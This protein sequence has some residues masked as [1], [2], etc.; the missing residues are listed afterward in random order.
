MANDVGRP[1]LLEDK[2][3]MLKIKELYLDG[4]TEDSIQEI[5]EVPKG[6]WNYWKHMNFHN[7][8]DILLS[9][10]HERMLNKAENNLDV[11]ME[12]E[13]DRVK[14][15]ASKFVAETIGKK[16]YSKRVE[17]SGIDGKE[18]PTP[19]LNAYV[20]NNDKP[21]ENISNEQE[22]S[23]SSGGDISIE[24]NIDTSLANQPSTDGQGEDTILGSLGINTTP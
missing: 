11:L 15:D 4:M 3:F 14:L 23:S 7:F 6:T 8:K 1:T 9:Y 13:D 22:D 18:L 20:L 2:K 17:Q 24:D 21:K 10:K 16:N 19:I 12:A 5:L